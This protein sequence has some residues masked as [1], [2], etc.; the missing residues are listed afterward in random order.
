MS[1]ISVLTSNTGTIAGLIAALASGETL[2]SVIA[3]AVMLITFIAGERFAVY[4]PDVNLAEFSDALSHGEILLMV[5]VPKKRVA[6]LERF[7]HHKH[8]D[9]IIGGVSWAIGAF[10]V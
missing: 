3:L 6:E 9:A 1:S 10:G 8:P 7:V 5:D 2:W 4:L